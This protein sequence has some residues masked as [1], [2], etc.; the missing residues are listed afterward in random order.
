MSDNY[1]DASELLEGPF[2]SRAR[3]RPR[4][5]TSSSDSGSPVYNRGDRILPRKRSRDFVVRA[6]P[7]PPRRLSSDFGGRNA[8]S[9]FRPVSSGFQGLWRPSVERECT[10][11]DFVYTGGPGGVPRY[12][13]LQTGNF[14][15][16]ENRSEREARKQRKQFEKLLRRQQEAAYEQWQQDRHERQQFEK[17]LQGNIQEFFGTVVDR[18]RAVDQ[19]SEAAERKLAARERQ[20]TDTLQEAE[21]VLEARKTV[22]R[23]D[24]SGEEVPPFSSKNFLIPTKRHKSREELSTSSREEGS[25]EQE[26]PQ[27]V[28]VSRRDVRGA[29]PSVA[30][31]VLPG[32]ASRSRDLLGYTVKPDRFDGVKKSWPEYKKYFEIVA[33]VKGWS[34]TEKAQA[35]AVSL[36]GNAQTV[37]TGMSAEDLLNYDVLIKRIENRY[38]PSGREAARRAELLHTKRKAGQE[39]ADWAQEVERLVLRA[40]PEA[41]GAHREVLVIDNFAKGIREQETRQWIQ[42]KN[43]KTIEE[44]ISALIHY[45][46]VTTSVKT[47]FPKK[48]R[49]SAVATVDTLTAEATPS[50]TPVKKN[51]KPETQEEA[52]SNDQLEDC[53]RT[54]RALVPG[55]PQY[56]KNGK[57]D[58]RSRNQKNSTSNGNRQNRKPGTKPDHNRCFRCDKE[59]HFIKTCPQAADK[60]PA[61]TEVRGDKTVSP[62]KTE[63]KPE[64]K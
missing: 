20:L 2:N 28:K 24:D 27:R 54:L 61:E 15:D 48:P 53:I 32:E 3:L 34:L 6:S 52:E 9:A 1:E 25:V 49:E 18:L 30:R 19:R 56:R 14:P 7:P 44:A 11:Q 41:E 29:E 33:T 23:E 57:G 22:E 45:E 12:S 39:P 59:G 35:L 37:L 16:W 55:T 21:R 5:E 63:Q 47:D 38:D 60:R 43:P 4:R 36:E 26:A 51:S 31:S 46:S 58:Y 17:T 13:E 10:Y 64:N 62:Q 8:P 50:S 40:Y 42:L